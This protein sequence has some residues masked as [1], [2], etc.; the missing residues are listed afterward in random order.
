MIGIININAHGGGGGIRT[1]DRLAPITVFETAAF[2]HSA[3]PPV[4]ELWAT[5]VARHNLVKGRVCSYFGHAWQD[6][7]AVAF[8]VCR[9]RGV[10]LVTEP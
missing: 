10:A 6:K 5:T 3:T 8:Y 4:C 7:G 1:L 9:L 2:D